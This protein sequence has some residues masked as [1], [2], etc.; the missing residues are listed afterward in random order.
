MSADI[1]VVIGAGMIALVFV[2]QAVILGAIHIATI[3]VR[4]VATLDA[5]VPVWRTV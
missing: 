3:P 1:I 4:V 2:L 5:K